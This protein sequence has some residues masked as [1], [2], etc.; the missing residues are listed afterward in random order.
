MRQIFIV[1]ATQVV[2]SD[3]HPEGLF[4]VATGFPKTFDSRAYPASEG[5]EHGKI[6]I[7]CTIIHQLCER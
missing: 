4:S 3:S 7:S 5:T 1:T 6:R 2:T